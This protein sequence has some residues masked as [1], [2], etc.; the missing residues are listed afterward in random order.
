MKSV[1]LHTPFASILAAIFRTVNPGGI[2]MLISLR[3]AV[4]DTGTF[5]DTVRDDIDLEDIGLVEITLLTFDSE[6]VISDSVKA[7]SELIT[8]FA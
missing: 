8:E 4:L 5:A 2:R 1:A 6:T 3:G 7:F